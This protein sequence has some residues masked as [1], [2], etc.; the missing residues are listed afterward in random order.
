MSTSEPSVPRLPGGETREND[1]A[2]ATVWWVDAKTWDEADAVLTR[3]GWTPEEREFWMSGERKSV[4]M[5]SRRLSSH[6]VVIFH[7]GHSVIAG[8]DGFGRWEIRPFYGMLWPI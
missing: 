7:V 1:D 3:Y 4:E 2:T 8:V 6:E 5:L